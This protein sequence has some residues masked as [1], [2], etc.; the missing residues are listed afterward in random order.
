MHAISVA[1]MLLLAGAAHAQQAN[2]DPEAADGHQ[3]EVYVSEETLQALYMQETSLLEGR[4]ATLEGG[5]FVTEHR[6]IVGIASVTSQVG[7]PTRF[8]RWRFEV[9]ARGYGALMEGEDQDVFGL[10]LGG[11]ARYAF[12][13]RQQLAAAIGAFY[14]PDILT[15]GDA[16]G[17]YDA[18][19]RLEMSLRDGLVAFV[20]YRLLEVDL[21]QN[22]ELDDH[23]HVGVRWTFSD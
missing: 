12:G 6:D 8:P 10:A 9:G 23:A 15:F 13:D 11:R 7:D 16:D 4:S 19:L 2:G 3:I 17:V 14:A 22:R 18:F 21:A 20:G 5:V 1:G